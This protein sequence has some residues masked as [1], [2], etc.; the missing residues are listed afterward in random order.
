MLRS[1][2]I[3]HVV[4]QKTKENMI[5]RTSIHLRPLLAL[6]MILSTSGVKPLYLSPHTSL[7]LVHGP[8][9]IDDKRTHRRYHVVVEAFRRQGR[10]K[11][12]VFD[13]GASP[14]FPHASHLLFLQP[15]PHLLL[16]QWL[17]L[18]LRCGI[19]RDGE[20]EVPHLGVASPTD[21][22]RTGTC[23]GRAA[24]PDALYCV[25]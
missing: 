1:V 11:V 4:D 25:T 17:G 18:R 12:Q 6:F 2:R 8:L 22:L 14:E 5:S 23:A 16:P 9:R 15:K 13:P 19:L 24:L 21:P 10:G 7:A 20:T 3:C